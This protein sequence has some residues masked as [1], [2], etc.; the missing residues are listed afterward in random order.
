[1]K[2]NGL[3]FKRSQNHPTSYGALASAD[4]AMGGTPQLFLCFI[5][6]GKHQVLVREDKTTLTNL[7]SR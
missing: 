7:D 3:S 2:W 6:S 5:T 1:M 4:V